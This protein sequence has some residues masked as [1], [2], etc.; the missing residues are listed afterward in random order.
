MKMRE[1]AERIQAEKEEEMLSKTKKQK[2]L[3]KERKLIDA[4][5]KTKSQAKKKIKVKKVIQD[6]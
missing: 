5:R 1:A 4:Y 3:E 2:S 6:S